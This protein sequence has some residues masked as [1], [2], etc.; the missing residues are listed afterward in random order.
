L[1]LPWL[2][3]LSFGHAPRPFDDPLELLAVVI[4]VAVLVVVLFE[5]S[6]DTLSK[7]R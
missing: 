2:W 3:N 6:P 5:P 1:L 4:V 7:V